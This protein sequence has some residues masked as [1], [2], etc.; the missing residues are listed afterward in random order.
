[1]AYRI[2]EVE[3][4]TP[5]WHEWRAACYTASQAPAVMGCNPW[6]PKTPRELYQL[7]TGQREVFVTAAMQR[8][9]DSEFRARAI[10]ND[11][12]HK[13]HGLCDLLTPICAEAEVNG[14]KL[15]ASL[16]AVTTVT[17]PK[18][19]R[20]KTPPRK[21]GFE[22]KTPNKGSE[23]DLWNAGAD[24]VELH[25]LWQMIHQMIVVDDLDELSLAVYAHDIDEV[26][27]V[28][29]LTRGQALEGAG[30]L[31]AAW[32]SFD[33]HVAA[34]REPPAGEGDVVEFD[35]EDATV[36]DLETDYQLATQ[37]L[38]DAEAK[39][40]AAKSALLDL[41]TARSGGA[42]AQSPR[43]TYFQTTRQG[44]VNWKAKPIAEALKTAGVDPEQYRGKPS[45]YWS[46]KERTP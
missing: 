24:K 26:R 13:A 27:I 1:M 33:D 31:L 35:G 8:G 45:T 21:I 44:N 6:F 46:I 14:I 9:N 4:G 37:A 12:I 15:G 10:L 34:F 38:K 19:V 2:V 39:V 32:R 28:R 20:G 40:E 18:K 3:Q 22:I 30:R 17:A 11:I 42:K 29:T 7:R 36:G 41:V 5:A 43:F 25:Y 16:D 23:S